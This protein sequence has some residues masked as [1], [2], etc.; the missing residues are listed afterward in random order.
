MRNYIKSSIWVLLLLSCVNRASGWQFEIAP[1]LWATNMNGRVQIRNQSAPVD[2]SF[3]DIV[4]LL[5]A[6]GMLWLSADQDK[7][8]LFANGLYASLSKDIDYAGYT[9]N[10]TN[11]LTIVSAGVSY[12]IYKHNN[13]FIEPYLGLRFTRNNAGIKISNLGF[14]AD[15]NQNWTDPILGSRIRYI[16]N[17][18]RVILA[19]DIGGTNFNSNKSLNLNGL[20]GYNPQTLQNWAFYLGYRYLYQKYS[21]G[22]GSDYFLWNMRLFGPMLGL[23]YSF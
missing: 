1:Y 23:S 21:T 5:K 12:Q 7:L 22:Q 14:D 16:N 19:A 2:E 11:K 3:A 18:W 6:G 8:G 17:G 4:K 10:S 13:Y 20:V 15:N 9:I